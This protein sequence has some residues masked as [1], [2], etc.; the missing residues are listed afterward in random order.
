[1]VR[2]RKSRALRMK[3]N[4]SAASRLKLRVKYSQPRSASMSHH[5]FAAVNL[6]AQKT[7]SIATVRTVRMFL[8][9]G[10]LLYQ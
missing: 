9:L 2:G 4:S 8:G 1:M 7:Q 6:H 3:N 10:F 5:P